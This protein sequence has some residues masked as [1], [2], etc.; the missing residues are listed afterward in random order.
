M[1][2]ILLILA[3]ILAIP[4]F[5]IG[6]IYSLITLRLKIKR[7]NDYAFTIALGID[8]LGNVVMSNLFNAILIQHDGVKFGNPDDTI[9]AILGVNKQNNTLKYL[10]KLLASLLNK[11]D[12]NH[13][14]KASENYESK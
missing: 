6:W 11:I 10:G 12:E 8:Q 13:V 5:I 7:L 2:F 14:E 1:G 9:S 4:L 3:I